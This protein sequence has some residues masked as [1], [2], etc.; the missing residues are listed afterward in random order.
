MKSAFKKIWKGIKVAAPYLGFAA[1][2]FPGGGAVAL[3]LL[4]I[5]NLI[6]QAEDIFAG[7]GTGAQKAKYVT[8]KALA[9]MEILTGKNVDNPKTRAIVEQIE[10]NVVST[11]NLSAQVQLLAEQ[12]KKLVDDLKDAIEDAKEPAQPDAP[13]PVA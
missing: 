5:E 8:A 11:K 7:E 12:Y 2:F 1:A 4:T 13:G 3:S 6:E 10:A 9:A